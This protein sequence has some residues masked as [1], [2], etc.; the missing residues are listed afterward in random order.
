MNDL[1]QFLFDFAFDQGFGIAQ[2]C[3][4]EEYRS[5]ADK[6]RNLIIINTNWK[7]RNELPFIIGHE[8]GHLMD[9]DTGISNYCGN[10]LT[11]KERH[12]DL[13]SLN[14]IFDYATIQYD[15]FEEPHD[16]MQQYGI[17]NRMFD[18]TVDLFRN[19]D[20]LLF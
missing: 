4:D 19:N 18:D 6:T 11:S 7:N 5:L 3:K 12:A 9:G 20:D 17:P 10:A 13:Y 8:I 2:I 1:I 15:S 16:F 14:L